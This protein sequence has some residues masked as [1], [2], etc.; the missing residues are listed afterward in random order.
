MLNLNI[1]MVYCGMLMIFFASIHY[2][3]AKDQKFSEY[4]NRSL[5]CLRKLLSVVIAAY[6]PTLNGQFLND[7]PIIELCHV[8]RLFVLKKK[9]V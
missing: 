7:L 9:T 4:I 1:N 8:N 2:K 5:S 3:K 6:G